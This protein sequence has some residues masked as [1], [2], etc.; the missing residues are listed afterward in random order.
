MSRVVLLTWLAMLLGLQAGCPARDARR[1]LDARLSDWRQAAERGDALARLQLVEALATRGGPG[2]LA[3]ARAHAEALARAGDPVGRAWVAALAEAAGEPDAAA[4]ALLALLA[5]PRAPEA[6]RRW[7]AVR[8][9]AQLDQ[10]ALDAASLDAV[11]AAV[12]DPAAPPEAAELLEAM[13]LRLPALPT[14]A[15]ALAQARAALG[16]VR[17]YWP[18]GR[19]APRP[20]TGLASV[21][22]RLTA[23]EAAEAPADFA[24]GAPVATPDGTVAFPE[25][26][27][28]VYAAALTL[29][30]GAGPFTL[31]VWGAASF[32]LIEGGRTLA[33]VD[34]LGAL[35]PERV[36]ATVPADA[37]PRPGLPRRVELHV[38]D[39]DAAPSVRVL[40]RP[41]RPAAPRVTLPP[42]LARLVALDLALHAGDVT[43]ADRAG[44]ALAALGDP[45]VAAPSLARAALADATRPRTAAAAQARQHLEAALSRSPEHAQARA[46]LVHL[47]RD[48]SEL[49]QAQGVAD[50]GPLAAHA[51]A[52][53]FALALD[54]G[55]QRRAAALADAR[56]ARLPSSC[57]AWEAVLD[58]RWEALKVRADVLDRPLPACPDLALRVGA[59]QHEAFRLPAARAVLS[60]LLAASPPGRPEARA[61]V[62]LAR[63]ALA[64]GDLDQARDLARQGLARGVHR[65]AMIDLLLRVALLEG[66]RAAAAAA[67]RDLGHVP[68]LS[69]AGRRRALDASRD[70]GLP[71]ADGHA[72]A[73]AALDETGVDDDASVRHLLEERHT[74]VLPGGALVHRVHRVVHLLDDAAVE[75]L[76]EI[77]LPEDAEIL[78]ARTWKPTAD[79]RLQPI[80]PEDF[81]EKTTISLPAL[82]AGAVAEV[83]WFWLEPPSPRLQPHWS[84]APFLFDSDRGHVATARFL[85]RAAPDAS[86]RIETL[87]DV[88]PPARPEPGLRVWT[89]QG[90][91]RVLPEPLDVRP[92]RRRASVRV[93][94]DLDL[95][96]LRAAL[97]EAL[98]PRLRPSPALDAL[99]RRALGDAPPADPRAR[100]SA[101]YDA[102]L[103]HVTEGQGD[104]WLGSAAL[105]A[106]SRSGD[107]VGLMVALCR[108]AGLDCQVALARPWTRGD[109]APWDGPAPLDLADFEYPLVRADLGDDGI[110]WLDPASRLVPFGFLSPLLEGAPALVV[111]PCPAP[112]VA[113]LPRDPAGEGERRVDAHVEIRPDGA[114][115]ATGQE[116][117]TGYYALGW[118]H[119]LVD[120][121]PDA[122]DRVLAGVVQQSLP[123]VSVDEVTLGGLDAR[124]GPLRLSWRA[125]GQLPTPQR[126]ATALT[127]GL[128]PERIGRATV[129][130]PQRR[131]PLWIART[132]RLRFS[133][134][135]TLPEGAAFPRAPAPARVDHPL[136]QLTREVALEEGGRVLRLDKRF[137]L[138]VGRVAPDDY[139]AW[140]EAAGAVDRADVLHLEIRWPRAAKGTP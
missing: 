119:V 20:A 102:V 35:A 27:P 46:A 97:A 57:A 16:A 45:V 124:G 93:S 61:R 80:E 39:R 106:A 7:A 53:A 33:R 139:P 47:L 134:Q 25:D 107:R 118:R 128:S 133:V 77:P 41:A 87:G 127:L 69:V 6:L 63:V 59:L 91:P 23:P 62:A 70:L 54:G 95:A 112:L 40:V 131:S 14:A 30:D 13:A 120:M 19:L 24:F 68:A 101:L 99:A 72:L 11:Q 8:A 60:A 104:P 78:I 136:M 74:T 15:D 108:A 105:T 28:G 31:E 125:T 92:D 12:A 82:E 135:I 73:L 4:A 138:G 2:G 88:P 67:R 137:S 32:R 126:D 83:A 79:G 81:L 18:T 38:A 21:P 52:V 37:D 65:E 100:L 90:R 55:E 49:A 132:G 36:T 121:A 44:H 50:A 1:S 122:R 140:A 29:P 86:L 115:V 76:G 9:L 17:Q 109:P 43:A 98:A 110:L 111:G 42:V 5:D 85:L 10:I 75:E 123:G 117:L 96:E 84:L 56:A 129:V 89:V 34:R 71:L 114:F 26:G 66:D 58:A 64:A 116:V 94:S 103:D 3:E 22:P 48:G 130:V 51:D 113:T